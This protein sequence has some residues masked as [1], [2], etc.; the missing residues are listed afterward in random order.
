MGVRPNCR[1]P[2]EKC[3]RGAF[4]ELLADNFDTGSRIARIVR[5]GARSVVWQCLPSPPHSANVERDRDSLNAACHAERVLSIVLVD[6]HCN[7]NDAQKPSECRF[8]LSD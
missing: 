6:L 7:P 1:G 3:L 5:E 2:V 4:V 8:E